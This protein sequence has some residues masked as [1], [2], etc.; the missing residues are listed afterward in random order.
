MCLSTTPGHV[1]TSFIR[2]GAMNKIRNGDT[3]L[4]RNLH[5]TIYGRPRENKY[6][7]LL[8][9]VRIG[10]EYVKASASELTPLSQ[11]DDSGG[12]EIRS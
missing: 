2:K 8:Y 4:Y 10:N 6:R 7:G 5:G 11:T 1:G 9:T 12:P 3:V